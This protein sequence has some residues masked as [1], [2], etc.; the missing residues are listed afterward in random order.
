MWY[1]CCTKDRDT[2][3][4]VSCFEW[5]VSLSSSCF[6]EA[7]ISPTVETEIHVL[8]GALS[9]FPSC[10]NMDLGPELFPY[11]VHSDHLVMTQLRLHLL[12]VAGQKRAC[13]Y[14]KLILGQADKWCPLAWSHCL[15]PG[16]VVSLLHLP[17]FFGICTTSY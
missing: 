3:C 2:V 16:P 4:N 13:S 6:S 8:S 7:G 5:R 1:G 10:V 9:C 14:R 12:L 15:C 17:C 11:V